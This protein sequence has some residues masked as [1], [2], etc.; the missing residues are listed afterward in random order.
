VNDRFSQDESDA[1]VRFPVV[2]KNFIALVDQSAAYKKEVFIRE[3]SVHLARL[4]EIATRLPQ[5]TSDEEESDTE[6][7]IDLVAHLPASVVDFERGRLEEWRKIRG[8]LE[9]Y[10][11]TMD[12]Y[13][14]VFD[15]IR[16]KESI[17]GSL[18]DDIADTYLDLARG[19]NLLGSEAPAEDAYSRWHFDFWAHWHQHAASA[20]TVIL[21]ILSDLEIC[22]P[23]SENFEEDDAGGYR[24]V[25]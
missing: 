17:P 23:L 2:A 16:Q 13:M 7:Q 11:G 24:D 8:K 14:L 18:S 10:L 5:I 15:P 6:S 4:C 12:S 21:E 20:L 19:L 3:L 9:T 22:P 1:I 25:E